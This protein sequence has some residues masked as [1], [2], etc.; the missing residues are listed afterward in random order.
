H[1]RSGQNPALR[2]F[3]YRVARLARLPINVIFCYDGKERPTIKR[4]MKVSKSDHWMVRPTQRILDAF[5]IQW[6]MARSEAEAEL[7]LMNKEGIIDAVMTDDSDVFVFGA[8]TVLQNSTLSPDDT[9]KVYTADTIRERVARSLH[10]EGFILMAV[11]CGG[12]YDQTG[13][14]GCGCN[15]ALGLVRCG[16]AHGLCNATS[17]VPDVADSLR[18]W[19]RDVRDHL[20]H[21]PT[22]RIG[23]LR[24]TLARTLSDTFPD[25]NVVSS[26]LD[27]VVS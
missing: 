19:R 4:N 26:Y 15:T 20:A 11:C 27:P 1:P 3:I 13:L 14:R 7:A 18:V 12:D 21:D 23:R 16:L 17:N 22:K 6:V 10:R 9:I 8:Q 2:S 24:P 25:P 5:N